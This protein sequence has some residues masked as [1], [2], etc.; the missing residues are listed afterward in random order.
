MR[1]WPKI[2]VNI[3]GTLSAAWFLT[4]LFVTFSERDPE[5]LWALVP[6]PILWALGYSVVGIAK[7]WRRS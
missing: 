2:L 7:Q 6:L 1:Q 5:N 3:A 4:V